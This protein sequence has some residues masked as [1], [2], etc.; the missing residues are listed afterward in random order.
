MNPETR[1]I[2]I[3]RAH[4]RCE[5]C[6]GTLTQG[7]SI[8][9]RKPRQMGG[10][11]TAWINEPVNLLAVCGSGT[12]GCHGRI[13]SLRRLSYEYGWLV[14]QGTRPHEIP[15]CDLQ[16]RWFLLHDDLKLTIQLPQN[17]PNPTS[18]T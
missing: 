4:E 5:L 15:F 10:S 3:T 12:T 14:H 1:A 7:M 16:G 18:S 13:E 2:V 8:H 6:G 17:P 11:K 9:H